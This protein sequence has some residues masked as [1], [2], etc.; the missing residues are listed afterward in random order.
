M[1]V[2]RGGAAGSQQ[3]MK[4]IGDQRPRVTD[5]CGMLDHGSQPIQKVVAVLIVQVFFEAFDATHYYV[6]QGTGGVDAGLSK[7]G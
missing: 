4:M 6:V 5:R 2:A 1:T 3:Q 7:H